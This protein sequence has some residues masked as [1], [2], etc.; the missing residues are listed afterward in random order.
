MINCKKLL[1]K[2]PYELL[3]GSDSCQ[4][5]EVVCDSRKVVKDSLFI[6]IQG[7][8]FDGHDMALEVAKKGAMAIVVSKELYLPEYPQ[9]AIIKVE[10]TRSALAFISAAFFGNPANQLKVIGI[11]GTKGKTT[12]TY[13]VQSIL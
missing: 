7:A 9:V 3:Q 4:I 13:L 8:N 5:T 1:E 6:C 10:D 2:L 12:T 11:T